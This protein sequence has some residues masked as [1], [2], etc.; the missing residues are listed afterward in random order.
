MRD[1]YDPHKADVPLVSN[2]LA[3]LLFTR[4]KAS[5]VGWDYG[6][7]RDI[8]GNMRQGVKIKKNER[9]T[10]KSD[11]MIRT[12]HLDAEE[13]G[14]VCPHFSLLKSCCHSL[15]VEVESLS[16]SVNQVI[17]NRWHT[18]GLLILLLL[19]K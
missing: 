18:A 10:E 14:S 9:G 2:A 8:S 17:A 3:L 6:G 11:P 15:R 13:R 12:P 1:S 19:P 4:S 16:V 5:G 7:I